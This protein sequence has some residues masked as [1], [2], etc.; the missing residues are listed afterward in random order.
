MINSPLERKRKKKEQKNDTAIH[1]TP[2]SITL[3]SVHSAETAAHHANILETQI[4]YHLNS[5]L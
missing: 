5:M 2:Q 4:N 1:N 3:N